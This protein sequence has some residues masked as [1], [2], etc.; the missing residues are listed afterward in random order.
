MLMH[1]GCVMANWESRQVWW[2]WTIGGITEEMGR[3]E[4]GWQS[5]NGV[6]ARAA[7]GSMQL[8]GSVPRLLGCPDIPG[9]SFKSTS[10]DLRAGWRP[11]KTAAV[12][13]GG[14]LRNSAKL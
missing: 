14:S 11:I 10:T 12:Q 6:E 4:N 3:A 7:Q 5:K 8:S 13:Y 9:L 2:Q 1:V